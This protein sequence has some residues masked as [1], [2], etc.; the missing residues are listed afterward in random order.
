MSFFSNTPFKFK[1]NN[2]RALLYRAYHLSSSYISFT[3][4]IDFLRGFFVNNGYPLN[5]FEL[6]CKRFLNRIF[7]R[8]TPTPTVERM[9]L[10]FSLPYYGLLSEKLYNNL[11]TSS[12]NYTLKSVSYNHLKIALRSALSFVLRTFSLRSYVSTLFMN[13]NVIAAMHLMSEVLGE[14]VRRESINI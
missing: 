3:Y 12:Q 4:E 14:G 11:A 2:I 7:T 8:A 13:L 6:Q 1:I 5:T 9:K 10:Y